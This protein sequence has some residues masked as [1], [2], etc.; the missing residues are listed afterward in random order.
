MD[1]ARMNK[2]ARAFG[3][4]RQWTRGHRAELRLA[5]R[6][7]VSALLAYAL[8][9]LLHVP[10]VLWTVLTATIMSQ[11]SLGRSVKATLDYFAGTLG[12]ALFSGFVAATVPHGGQAGYLVILAVGVP[13]VALLAALW[14]RFASAPFTA[15]MVLLAPTIIHATP[16]ESAVFRVI[17]VLLGGLVALFVS[18]FVLPSRAQALS[19]EHAAAMLRRMAGVLRQLLAGCAG[20]LDL[21]RVSDIQKG[22]GPAL[23]RLEIFIDEARR[24][25]LARG[26]G[27]ALAPLLPVLLRLRHDLVIIGRAVLEPL[28]GGLRETLSGRIDRV[29]AEGGGFLEASAGALAGGPAASL[30]AFEAALAAYDEDIAAYRAEGHM[31]ALGV[32]DLER[33]FAL[34]FALEQLHQDF[35]ALRGWIEAFGAV[36]WR[37]GSG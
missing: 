15:V 26:E 22:L 31:R 24:E 23:A 37:R 17:E 5:V 28:P 35:K 11:L 16:L 13:P 21:A 33:L 10:Q 27:H 25:R 8:S 20:P 4:A 6:V 30:D 29:S 1:E 9:L 34:G 14:P 7:T 3:A 2:P 36:G 32:D 18:F 12:G 19:V